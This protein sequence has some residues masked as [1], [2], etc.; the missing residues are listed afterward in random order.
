[1]A[2]SNASDS[3]IDWGQDLFYLKDWLDKHPQARP[4]RFAYYHHLVDPAVAGIEYTK[5]PW[6]RPRG[7]E[8]GGSLGPKPG[9]YAVSVNRLVGREGAHGYFKYLEPA[10]WA[11]YSIHV[12]YL[13]RED[14]NLVRRKLNLPELPEA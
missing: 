10:A 5:A 1:M 11:G 2:A 7:H 9:W 14:A 3:N 6:G 12:Y 4:I 13:T 8:R